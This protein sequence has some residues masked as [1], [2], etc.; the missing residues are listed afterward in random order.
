MASSHND[1]VASATAS[2][3]INLG[4]SGRSGETPFVESLDVTPDRDYQTA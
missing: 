1:K 2:T 4:Q 3:I